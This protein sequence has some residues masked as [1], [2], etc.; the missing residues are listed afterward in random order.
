ML[1]KESPRGF[2][3]L[4]S[5]LE[6]PTKQNKSVSSQTTLKEHNDR[7]VEKMKSPY[8]RLWKKVIRAAENGSVCSHSSFHIIFIYYV[9]YL[10]AITYS[11]INMYKKVY[12]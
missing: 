6:F 8:K 12:Q 3:N 5:G 11:F 7:V 4:T 10:R 2:M 1:G 9:S